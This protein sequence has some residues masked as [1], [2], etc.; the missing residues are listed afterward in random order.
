MNESQS[1]IKDNRELDDDVFG[2]DIQTDI[3]E[4]RNTRRKSTRQRQ[5][6]ERY[7][8]PV[9]HCIHYVNANVLN[10]FEEAINSNENHE[11]K[12]AMEERSSV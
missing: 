4:D 10:T 1:E 3:G 6:V 2:G 8:N 5:S 9:T 7:G 12:N 11:W